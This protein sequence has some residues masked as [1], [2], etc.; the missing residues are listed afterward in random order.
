MRK[1]TDIIILKNGGNILKRILGIGAV[2]LIAMA[3]GLSITREFSDIGTLII[4][5]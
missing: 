4:K 5:K 3:L 2:V 1:K